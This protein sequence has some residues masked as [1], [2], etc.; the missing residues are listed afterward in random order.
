M[1][2]SLSPA[3]LVSRYTVWATPITTVC[4][5]REVVAKKTVA[6]ALNRSCNGGVEPVGLTRLGA[7]EPTWTSASWRRTARDLLEVDCIETQPHCGT[8]PKPNEKSLDQVMIKAIPNGYGSS[9]AL[10][11]VQA[12]QF[13]S[14]LRLCDVTRFSSTLRQSHFLAALVVP[15]SCQSINTHLN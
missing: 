12:A 7:N 11:K 1:N 4:H 5:V 3:S 2:Q 9:H 15:P 13:L 10:A 6:F 14:R 8:I